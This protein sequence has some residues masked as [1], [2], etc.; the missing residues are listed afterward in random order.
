VPDYVCRAA[1]LHRLIVTLV[2]SSDG[3]LLRRVIADIVK[4]KVTSENI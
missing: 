4:L 1:P 3:R 2:D